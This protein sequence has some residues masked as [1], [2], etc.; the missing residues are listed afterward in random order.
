[1]FSESTGVAED[2]GGGSG[3]ETESPVPVEGRRLDR[4]QL[5]A[6]LG[7]GG[8]GT[9][10]RARDLQLDRE[11]AVKVPKS[12]LFSQADDRRRF[13][14]EAQNAAQLRHPGIV[15]VYEVGQF[16][17]VPFLVMELVEGQPLSRYLQHARPEIAVAVDLVGQIAAALQHAHAAGVIHRDLKPSNI[18]LD[19]ESRP[20]ILDFGLGKRSGVD[21]SIDAEG[22]VVGT[23]AYM[24]PEQA[25]GA[26]HRIGPGSDIYS[27]GVILFEL[28]TG[29]RPFRGDPVALLHKVVHAE[30]P[31]PRSE[32]SRVSRDLETIVLKCLEKDPRRRFATA[33][34][35]ADELGRVRRGEPILARPVSR[36]VRAGRWC[37]RNPWPAGSAAIVIGMLVVALTAVSAS[38]RHVRQ[39]QRQT[40]QQLTTA[41]DVIDHWYT[42][43]GSLLPYYPE[44]QQ[45]LLNK[46]AEDY[47]RFVQQ[48]FSDP[49]LERERGRTL[50]RLLAVRRTLGQLAAAR[51]AGE[52]AKAVFLRLCEQDPADTQSRVSLAQTTAELANLS[53]SARADA[54][55]DFHEALKHMQQ[56]AAAEPANALLQDA[57]ATTCLNLGARLHESRRWPEA[58][59]KLR[60]AIRLFQ[61]LRAS[62]AAPRYAA[63]Q[64][65][66]HNLCGAVLA[67]TGQVR[68]AARQ[69]QLAIDLLS[70]LV[71]E[72]TAHPQLLEARGESYEFLASVQR[73]LGQTQAVMASLH[74]ASE[75][76]QRLAAAVPSWTAAEKL[77][78]AQVNAA[79]LQLEQGH[80]RHAAERLQ[81]ASAV[82]A[83]LAIQVDLP[84]LREQWATC[85]DQLAQAYGDLGENQQALAAAD[86][87]TRTFRE[88]AE[89]YP[90]E[91]VYRQRWSVAESHRGRLL[92]KLGRHEEAVAAF[93]RA[94]GEAEQLV[95]RHADREEFCD[96]LA[97]VLQY[98]AD[99]LDELG[100]L[101]A[102]DACRQRCRQLWEQLAQQSASPVYPDRLARFLS[103]GAAA[104]SRDP[105]EAVAWARRSTLAAPNE[106][107]FHSALAA[108]LYRDGQDAACIE[109]VAAAAGT[110]GFAIAEDLFFRALAQVNLGKTTEAALDFHDAC[111]WMEEHQPDRPELNRLRS[112]AEREFAAIQEDVND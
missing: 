42:G 66:A 6:V 73:R 44:V 4:F 45:E 46:A 15:P 31:S 49:G 48:G 1:L 108:A 99:L 27:L 96:L 63:G 39:A 60:W 58:E 86:E 16:D 93:Q 7:Q 98:Q 80:C 28:L 82:L 89:Q 65:S 24:S 67:E 12:G 2:T 70:P 83:E 110:R 25:L 36:A 30:P 79:Q 103:Q 37:R 112:E 47:E 29:S 72:P 17:G 23:Y 69:I 43:I 104:R 35:V 54:D 87:A 102:A 9:V 33:A 64:A 81:L 84:R 21:A 11:V 32:N 88:L 74:A 111:R 94:S 51:E 78:A 52:Q 68:E 92:H 40:L 59:D 10:Y 61:S 107:G 105:A 106:A 38:L 62:D 3:T 101:D 13:L 55:R 18:L 91:A 109:A 8:F 95:Q 75:D 5:L 97:F 76:Y 50:L 56:L 20:R 57:L 100:Q 71:A 34:E 90:D 41:R 85:D 53:W 26:V 14:R 77:A 22:V 19:L